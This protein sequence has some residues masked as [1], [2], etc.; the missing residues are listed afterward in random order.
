VWG[1]CSD[2]VAYGERIA[3]KFLDSTLRKSNNPWAYS[4]LHNNRVGRLVSHYNIILETTTKRHLSDVDN[5]S[6]LCVIRWR[7]TANATA[8]PGRAPSRRAG[9]RWLAFPRSP[10]NFGRATT[11]QWG[12]YTVCRIPAW[13]FLFVRSW[14][15]LWDHIRVA[16][17]SAKN[18][19]RQ[20]VTAKRGKSQTPKVLTAILTLP[21][22]T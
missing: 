13:R 11:E 17:I 19:K 5:V 9:R 21:Y 20:S 10:P 15:L 7:S 6:R 14:S 3:S 16:V 1:G 22:L 2:H 4:S 12:K 8:F 18:H